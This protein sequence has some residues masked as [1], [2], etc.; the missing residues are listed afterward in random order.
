MRP[1]ARRH[2]QQRDEGPP[3]LEMSMA[4]P[5]ASA[6]ARPLLVQKVSKQPKGYAEGNKGVG[7]EIMM[8]KDPMQRET[9]IKIMMDM[10]TLS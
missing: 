7:L 6:A 3:R 2:K 10:R 1:A 5:Q 8:E 9:S 4:E